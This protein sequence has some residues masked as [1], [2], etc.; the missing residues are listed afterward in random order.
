MKRHAI[1]LG[2]LTF[3]AICSAG[4]SLQAQK[5]VSLKPDL[6]FHFNCEGSS[7]PPSDTAIEDFLR[8]RGFNV[9]NKVRLAKKHHVDFPFN[10]FIVGIDDQHRMIEL[11]STRGE[12][13]T[14]ALNTPPPT[15]HAADLEDAVLKFVSDRLGCRVRQIS[16]GENGDDARDF[17]EEIFRIRRG[18]FRQADDMERPPA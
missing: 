2:A 3:A 15:R 17:Y 16:R 18:W 11:E 7:Y 1:T 4:S 12:F 5:A 14:V 13:F 9:L 8:S 10:L 6:A